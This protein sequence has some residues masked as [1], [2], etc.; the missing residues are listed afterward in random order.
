MLVIQGLSQSLSTVPSSRVGFE[1]CGL[2]GGASR[3]WQPGRD[4]MSKPGI[5]NPGQ[6]L[7]TISYGWRLNSLARSRSCRPLI[8]KPSSLKHLDVRIR[9]IAL[10]RGGGVGTRGLQ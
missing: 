7:N 5:L 1:V 9:F 10:I 3:I 6:A 2:F 4:P 8:S